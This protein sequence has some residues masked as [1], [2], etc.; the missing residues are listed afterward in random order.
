[1]HG[2]SKA[3]TSLQQVTLS[4]AVQGDFQRLAGDLANQYSDRARLEFSFDEPLSHLIYA[5]CDLMLVPSMF[6]PCGLTQMI[7]MR[8]GTISVVRKTGGLADTVFDVDHDQERAAEYGM[9]VRAAPAAAFDVKLGAMHSMSSWVQCIRCGCNAFDV[10]LGA[11]HSMS[12]WVQCI[13]CQCI[14][15][16]VRLGGV[17][18]Q[19]RTQCCIGLKKGEVRAGERLELRGHGQRRTRLRAEPGHVHVVQRARALP[20]ARA[21]LHAH[22]LGLER[23]RARLRRALLQGAQ[24]VRQQ[25]NVIRGMLD[26]ALALKF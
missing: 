3:N 8:Y 17:G 18:G 2:C 24:G 15:C 6:E 4:A 25:G 5:G 26:C 13:R 9:Q 1:M 11:M 7:G 19:E 12:S 22:R 20:R 14:R 10:N 21:A 16:Q 23:P